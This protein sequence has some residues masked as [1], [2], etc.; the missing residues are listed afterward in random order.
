MVA[1]VF[2]ARTGADAGAAGAGAAHRLHHRAAA[3][4]A[5]DLDPLSAAGMLIAAQQVLIGVA[6]GFGCR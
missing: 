2:G 4:A 3:A 6:M 1:P 5:A